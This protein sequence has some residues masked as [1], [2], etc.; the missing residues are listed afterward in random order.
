MYVYVSIVNTVPEESRDESWAAQDWFQHKKSW[1]RI[2]EQTEF[3]H[4]CHN[5]CTVRIGNYFVRIRMRG[6]VIL[7]TNP[8]RINYGMHLSP[9]WKFCGYGKNMLINRYKI[10]ENI[11]L[12]KLKFLWIF[13]IA[14]IH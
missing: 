14:G 9:T 12:L 4:H 11:E 8:A 13:E 10:L 2:S 1:G 6:S 3:S 7:K 5:E